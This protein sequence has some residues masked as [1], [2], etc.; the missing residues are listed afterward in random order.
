MHQRYTLSLATITLLLCHV[1]PP[2][3]RH[4]MSALLYCD[5]STCDTYRRRLLDHVAV[6]DEACMRQDLR[7]AET[8]KRLLLRADQQ[9]VTRRH[10]GQVRQAAR[11]TCGGTRQ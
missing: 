10:L 5:V 4:V 9:H 1:T 11:L 2:L 6:V 3:Q 7:A 8:L